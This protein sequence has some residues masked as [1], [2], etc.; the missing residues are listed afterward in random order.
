M[1]FAHPFVAVAAFAVALAFL[2]F[3]LR[4]ARRSRAAALDYSQLAFLEAAAGRTPWNA[5]FAGVWTL[6]I[7]A[8]GVALARPAIVA[9]I[10]VHDASVVLCIDTS[11][12]MAS[13]DVDPSR[14]DAARA[15]AS[16]FVDGVPAGTRIGIVAFSTEAI[17][18]GALTDDRA[19]AEDDLGRI[20]P[21]NGG[22]AI[23]DALA[24][25]ADLL[26]AAGRR[27]IVLVTDGV[28]NHGRDP[29]EVARA[30]GASGIAIFTI[31]IGTNGSGQLIPGTG[32]SA[33][34]DED[35]LREIAAAG[36]GTYARVADA[37]ALRTRLGALAQTTVRERRH[38][39][40]T[41]PIAIGGG[42]LG[43][44]ATIVAL[45]LG[46]FP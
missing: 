4:A 10:P 25:A 33:E 8:L 1:T 16:T 22:T 26:P 21:P 17:P 6:A 35:A 23:G 30:V 42:M 29:L 32:E 41:L 43:A 37:G 45:A 40:L 28:N 19:T 11:G 3:A 12:S 46:R 18:L 39:D 7:L 34:I 14:A 44:I 9:A 31:G 38:V 13:T 36:N 20:P 2:A 24:A 27:A 15:A 5:I